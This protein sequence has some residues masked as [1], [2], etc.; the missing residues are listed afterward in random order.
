MI[1][2]CYLLVIRYRLDMQ[3]QY[4]D[5]TEMTRQ[6]RK[7]AVVT[8]RIEPRLKA[9]AEKAAI[10]DQRSLTNFIEVLIVERCKSL[11]I[12]MDESAGEKV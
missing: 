3:M 9:A 2:D 4:T 8:L 11:N 1:I 7:T 5:Y 12:P 10:H 6:K